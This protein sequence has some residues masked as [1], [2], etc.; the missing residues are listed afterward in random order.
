MV[1]MMGMD[2]VERDGPMGEGS[3]GRDLCRDHVRRQEGDHGGSKRRGGLRV[4][5][6]SSILPPP[7]LG[8]DYQSAEAGRERGFTHPRGWLRGGKYWCWAALPSSSGCFR[9][10]AV[11]GKGFRLREREACVGGPR[12][13]DSNRSA[14]VCLAVKIKIRRDGNNLGARLRCRGC[15]AAARPASR[16]DS[17]GLCG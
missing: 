4:G 7:P 17:R 3:R 13:R 9:S 2:K 8:G 6:V 1:M 10:E 5:C 16:G 11:E 15:R 12:P 14:I